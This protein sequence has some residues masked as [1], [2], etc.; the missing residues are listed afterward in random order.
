M[1]STT[2]KGPKPSGY[3]SRD[4]GVNVRMFFDKFARDRQMDPLAPDT[5][6]S[7]TTHS[8]F[9]KEVTGV[10]CAVGS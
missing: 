8:V 2:A 5:W 10:E 7:V 4:E 9:S 6:Y 1:N 3:W